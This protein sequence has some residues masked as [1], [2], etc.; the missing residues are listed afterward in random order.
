MKVGYSVEGSTDRAFLQGLHRW[1]PEAAMVEGPFRGSTRTSRRRECRKICDQFEAQG[2]DV[3]LFLADGDGKPWREVQ[4]DE[5]ARL[6]PEHLDRTVQG[7]PDRNIECWLCSD[8]GWLAR[9]LGCDPDRFRVDD[10]KPAFQRTLG[11]TRDEKKEPEIA[12]LVVE[13]PLRGW[14]R[15]TSF[16]N[17]YDQLRECSNRLGC[18]IENLRERD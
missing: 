6:P 12:A 16:E 5:K 9:T 14:L 3:L 18:T 11:I 17:F 4:R 7:V 2:V 15:N 8:A 13:A 1:C 10:P